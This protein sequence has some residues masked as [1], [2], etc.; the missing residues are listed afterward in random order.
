MNAEKESALQ[1]AMNSA[2]AI[3]KEN[4]GWNL[5]DFYFNLPPLERRAVALGNLNY[6]VENGGF[7]QWVFNGYREASLSTLRQI[8]REIEDS[9]WE[10]LKQGIELALSVSRE[11]RE[12]SR[13]D[14]WAEWQETKDDKYY[15]LENIEVEMNAYI[16]SFRV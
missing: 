16:E 8:Q 13:A 11:P 4:E 12:E 15:A 9:K 3:W 7:T 2:Y 6:Q 14:D 10:E 1:E 5:E